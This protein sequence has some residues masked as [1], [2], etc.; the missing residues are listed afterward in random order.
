MHSPSNIV[1]IVHHRIGKPGALPGFNVDED[2]FSI[3]ITDPSDKSFWLR[4]AKSGERIAP[5]LTVQRGTVVVTD[6]KR[7]GVAD[8]AI[9]EALSFAAGQVVAP[10]GTSPT[11]LRYL[12]IAP[13]AGD[14]NGVLERAQREAAHL[15]GITVRFAAALGLKVAGAQI[16]NRDGKHDFEC[17]LTHAAAD[18]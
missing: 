10:A 16:V 5:G 12:D 9:A 13:A 14:A 15:T 17:T 3:K 7:S 18:R 6:L 1:K 11:S 4:V 2:D 8:A